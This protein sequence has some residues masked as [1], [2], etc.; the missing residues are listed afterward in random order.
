MSINVLWV[1]DEPSSLRYEVILA[2]R[3]GWR[4]TW[5]D[6]VK[7]GLELLRDIA[8]DLVVVDLILSRDDFEKGRGFVDANAGVSL[9]ES[10]REP[11]RKG[12]TPP[13]VP[14][15]V[16]TAV[17]NK[18]TRDKVLVKL[19]TSRFYQTKPLHEKAYRDVVRELTERLGSSLQRPSQPS[20]STEK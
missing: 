18:E 20:P 19:E 2:E 17:V 14:L 15:L 3:H 8:F 16:I 12:L 13:N 11:S 10:I 1:E 4:I 7:R 9:V 6:T 5:A